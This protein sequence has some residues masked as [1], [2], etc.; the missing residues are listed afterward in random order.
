MS[1]DLRKRITIRL[2]EEMYEWV[3]KMGGAEFGRRVLEK[4]K[5][6]LDSRK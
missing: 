3:M 5:E 4:A 2:D 1:Q 6:K